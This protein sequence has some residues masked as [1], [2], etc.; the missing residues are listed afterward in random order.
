MWRNPWYIADALGHW[1][2][3]PTML[4]KRSARARWHH[5]IHLIPGW[6]SRWACN[7][8]DLSLG[9][10]WGEV[11]GVSATQDG[12]SRLMRAAPGKVSVRPR[13]AWPSDDLLDRLN[14]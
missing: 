8:Y 12:P 5:R 9:M 1:L 6:L 14:E 4:G 11:N 3:T 10:T 7:R 13:G 2:Y